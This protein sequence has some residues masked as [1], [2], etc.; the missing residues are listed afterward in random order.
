MSFNKITKLTSP[1]AGATWQENAD[2]FEPI[3]PIG[4]PRLRGC[5]GGRGA[6]WGARVHFI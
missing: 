5:A 3:F 2:K 6:Q 4:E 1:D